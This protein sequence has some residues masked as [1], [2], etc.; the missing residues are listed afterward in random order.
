MIACSKC[1]AACELKVSP[2]DGKPRLACKRC[3]DGMD[4]DPVPP[5]V[6]RTIAKY[7]D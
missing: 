5:Y 3:G 6:A 4:D 1:G 7:L 2:R